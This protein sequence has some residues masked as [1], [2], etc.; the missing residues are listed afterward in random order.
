MIEEYPPSSASF[1]WQALNVKVLPDK[2]KAPATETLL[3]TAVCYLEKMLTLPA[4][5]ELYNDTVS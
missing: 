2:L 5:V 3:K 4:T 1:A